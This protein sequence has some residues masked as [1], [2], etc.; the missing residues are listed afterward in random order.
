[1]NMFLEKRERSLRERRDKRE[2]S[3]RK[4]KILWWGW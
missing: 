2:K 1:M 4:M 3:K